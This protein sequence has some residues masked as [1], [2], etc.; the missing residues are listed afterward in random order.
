MSIKAAMVDIA[1]DYTKKRNVFRLGTFSGS[2]Y[3][4][5]VSIKW[6]KRLQFHQISNW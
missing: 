2:E 6:L 5:Q 1:Y 4:I 3:L